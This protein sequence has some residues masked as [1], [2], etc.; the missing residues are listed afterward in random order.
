MKKNLD[1]YM[2]LPYRVEIIPEPDNSGFTAYIPD[3]PGCVTSAESLGEI[4]EMLNEA[5]E[6]WVEI[7]I[8]DGEYIPEPTPLKDEQYSG[9]FVTRIPKS[10]HRQL[11]VRA[12]KESTSLNQLVLMILSE[13]MGRW[14]TG[15]KQMIEYTRILRDYTTYA[16]FNLN[17]IFNKFETLYKQTQTEEEITPWDIEHLSLSVAGKIKVISHG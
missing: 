6:L 10:L 5:Q 11:S 15:N 8:E 13:G 7:A 4:W 3:L 2:N 9:K 16:Q 1:Y 12:E 17:S 14:I